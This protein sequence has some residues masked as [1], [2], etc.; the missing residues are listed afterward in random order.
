MLSDEKH[1]DISIGNYYT[2]SIS[3]RIWAETKE[4]TESLAK[5]VVAT[6]DL[7]KAL[8]DAR[9][10]MKAVTLFPGLKPFIDRANKAIDKA[11]K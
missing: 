1:Q 8:I 4:E 7:L 5:L 11:V 6:P 3:I 10:A 2:N 9:D